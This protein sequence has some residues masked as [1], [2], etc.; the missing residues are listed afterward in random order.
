MILL[1]TDDGSRTTEHDL[2]QNERYENDR[3]NDGDIED[4][5]PKGMIGVGQVALSVEPP[6]L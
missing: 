3:N 1:S 5:C 4:H 6:L 2:N